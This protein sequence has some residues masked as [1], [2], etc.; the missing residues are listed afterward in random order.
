MAARSQDDEAE[1]L[2]TFFER[3]TRGFFAEVRL[4]SPTDGSRTWPL[5]AA[6]WTG[7]LVEPQP[8]LAAFLVAARKAAVF[9]CACVAPDAAGEP[10]ALRVTSPLA[11]ID[12]GRPASIPPSNYTI[13]VPTRTLDDVL[14]EADAPPPLDFLALQVRIQR[15]SR[16]SRS[17]GGACEVAM[18]R[19]GGVKTR[20]MSFDFRPLRDGRGC[21][22]E[23]SHS[24]V[25]SSRIL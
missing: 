23:N 18:D 21:R 25:V 6:G 12:V 2:F 15:S 9:A 10:L 20:M 7:A 11:G 24:A 17:L 5:E 19:R 13:M 8:D 22:S 16:S 4:R 1:R 14:R 3:S